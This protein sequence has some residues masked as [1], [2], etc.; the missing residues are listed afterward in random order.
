MM[1]EKNNYTY[2]V[3]DEFDDMYELEFASDL[4]K[5]FS[6]E[7][8]NPQIKLV[9]SKKY[10]M[11]FINIPIIPKWLDEYIKNAQDVVDA[12]G[13]KY[14]SKTTTIDVLSYILSNSDQY[15]N[16]KNLM[17]GNNF[18]KMKS[19]VGAIFFFY[20]VNDG[21]NE[22]KFDFDKNVGVSVPQIDDSELIKAIDYIKEN[23]ENVNLYYEI[24]R[25]K[26]TYPNQQIIEDNLDDILLSLYVGYK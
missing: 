11:K 4:E 17:N 1:N 14:N 20:N 15:D 3:V 25:I 19:L 7:I 5:V 2:Y 13:I 26:E 6:Q 18:K 10:T 23:I 21:N 24:L 12:S 16:F 9:N 22:I 8:E